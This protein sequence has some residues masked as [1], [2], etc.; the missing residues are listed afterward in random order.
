MSSGL[1]G[2]QDPRQFEP[3]FVLPRKKHFLKLLHLIILQFEI[4]TG[5]LR[6]KT[7]CFI[8]SKS[9]NTCSQFFLSRTSASSRV[10]SSITFA[11]NHKQT[12]SVGGTLSGASR[13]ILQRHSSTS[14][15]TI[16]LSLSFLVARPQF[17][18]MVARPS[19]SSWWLDPSFLHRLKR[20]LCSCC[21]P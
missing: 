10:Y 4:L 11:P 14:P 8:I 1:S 19:F 9:H 12:L 2:S 16:S 20:A 6:L 7:A 21:L 5:F 15:C 3:S 18:F 17:S 13:G